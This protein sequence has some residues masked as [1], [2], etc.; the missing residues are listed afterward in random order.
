ML[1]KGVCYSLKR[2]IPELVS[3]INHKIINLSGI[4]VLQCLIDW[5]EL[6]EL[7]SFVSHNIINLYGIHTGEFCYIKHKWI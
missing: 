1:Y 2:H 7:I 3:F 4:K 6:P 5:K